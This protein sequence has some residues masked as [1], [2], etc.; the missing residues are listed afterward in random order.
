MRDRLG[1][2]EVI[3]ALARTMKSEAYLELGVFKP[4]VTWNEVTP[5]VSRCVG[6]DRLPIRS[7]DPRKPILCCTTNEYFAGHRGSETFD[8]IFID[9]DHSFESASIDLRNSLA[10]LRVNGVIV[11]HDTDPIDE[12]RLKP[13]SCGDSY[14][15]VEYAKTIGLDA[16]NLPVCDP[17]LLIMRRA[18]ELRWKQP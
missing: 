3:A 1:H 6:V 8:L 2:G 16:V 17:G 10:A 14:R 13:V 7:N 9:A 18:G 4:K 12:N 15:L 11:A 5:H